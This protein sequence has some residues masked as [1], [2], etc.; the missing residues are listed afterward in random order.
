MLE[1]WVVTLQFLANIAVF[2]IQFIASSQR[3]PQDL[4]QNIGYTIYPVFAREIT[5][6]WGNQPRMECRTLEVAAMG[7]I[8]VTLNSLLDS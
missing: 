2:S 5:D 1:V 3:W 6:V 8:S 7:I 4:M